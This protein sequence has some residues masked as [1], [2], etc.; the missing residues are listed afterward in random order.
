M[1]E[2]QIRNTWGIVENFNNFNELTYSVSTI[3]GFR[4]YTLFVIEDFYPEINLLE[5]P[6]LWIQA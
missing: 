2:I 1:L 4:C 3:L 6:I 5:S